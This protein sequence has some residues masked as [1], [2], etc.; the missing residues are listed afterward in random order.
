[1][2]CVFSYGQNCIP[3]HSIDKDSL[4][5]KPGEHYKYMMHYSWGAL[6]SDV[7]W[8]TVDLDTLTM[9][10]QKAFHVNVIGHTAGFYDIFFKVRENFQSWF[11][12]DGLKPLKFY[13]SSLEGKYRARNLYNYIWDAGEPYIDADVWST[14]R[15]QRNE[16]LPLRECLYDLPT[17]YYVARNMDFSKVEPGQR[18]PMTFAIDEDICDVYFIMYGREEKKIKGL[19]TVD[20]IKFAAKL[21]A[22]TVFTGEADMMIWIS[23]DENRIPVYF[24]A[25]LLVGTAS[26]RLI[27]FSGTKYPVEVKN[28]KKR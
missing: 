14:S 8:A 10:G 7:G 16:M 13:R 20:C 21:L 6:N 11:T 19:G 23:N 17:L 15:G 24:E 1:M 12:I 4:A 5:Y 3:V 28:K 25:P 26:G 27:E 22:G 9:N 18:Y 2:F